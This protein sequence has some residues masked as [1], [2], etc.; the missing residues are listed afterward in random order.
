MKYLMYIPRDPLFDRLYA[1]K[2]LPGFFPKMHFNGSEALRGN[3]HPQSV[4]PLEGCQLGALQKSQ[5]L[6]AS[7]KLS[8]CESEESSVRWLKGRGQKKLKGWGDRKAFIVDT[9]LRSWF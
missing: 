6:L 9:I 4:L 8:P 3:G 1:K 7:C 2:R 5:D